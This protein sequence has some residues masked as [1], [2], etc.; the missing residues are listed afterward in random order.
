MRIGVVLGT[1]L[2]LSLVTS[3][4]TFMKIATFG[5]GFGFFGDPIFQR[6]T[7]YLNKKYPH[8]T[9]LLVPQK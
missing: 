6:I 9:E 1:A 2:L 7:K 3:S 8:W 4:Y 5:I